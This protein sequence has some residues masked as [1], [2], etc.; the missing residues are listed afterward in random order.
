MGG[1]PPIASPPPRADAC[2][3]QRAC[4]NPGDP[5]LV[6]KKQRRA[7]SA[8]KQHAATQLW[9]LVN[10]RPLVAEHLPA[11]FPGAKVPG[12]Q[13]GCWRTKPDHAFISSRGKTLHQQ[14]MTRSKNANRS[15]H[16]MSNAKPSPA[17]LSNAGRHESHS[18]RRQY[19][20][21]S[22]S[23]SPH[24]GTV[25]CIL[26]HQWAIAAEVRAP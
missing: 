10:W 20:L 4:L 24:S 12:N 1:K 22:S 8:K 9:T 25:Y 16:D 3:T 14:T 26:R 21:S 11:A 17:G 23:R 7:R 5:S 2:R 6:Q 18:P 15:H 13:R 19:A